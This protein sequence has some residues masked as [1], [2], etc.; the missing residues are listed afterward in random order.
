MSLKFCI[1]GQ[2]T[3]DAHN[4]ISMSTVHCDVQ[5]FIFLKDV[6]DDYRADMM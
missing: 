2:S 4:V 5:C 6:A 3:S 1:T